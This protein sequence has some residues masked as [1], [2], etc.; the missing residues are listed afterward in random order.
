MQYLTAGKKSRVLKEKV[1]RV[2]KIIAVG[3]VGILL[4]VL[5]AESKIMFP[6]TMRATATIDTTSPNLEIVSMESGGQTIQGLLYN[7]DRP[8]GLIILCHGN[9]EMLGDLEDELGWFSERYRVSVLAFDYRG[10][11][12]SEGAPTQNRLYQDGQAAYDFARQRGFSPEEIVLFGRS[13]GGAVAVDIAS[14][15]QVAGMGLSN[16]FSSMTD[17][18][19]SKFIWLPVRLVLRNRFPSAKRIE[20][21]QGPL[22]QR[23]GTMDQIVPIR[24]GKKLFDSATQAE[25]KVFVEDPRGTHNQNLSENFWSAFGEML[26]RCLPESKTSDPNQSLQ[27]NP[28]RRD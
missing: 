27:S 18:A 7:A 14:K 9:G 5:F 21:Y 6:G 22:V 10:Y 11:G 1:F 13:L 19:A 8:R 26:D 12:N 20:R 16:T 23:H 4:L 28:S 2:L 15:N 25:S 17:V 24:F 3:Y